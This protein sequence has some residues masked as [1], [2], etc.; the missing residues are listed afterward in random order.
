MRNVCC[1]LD[2]KPED[3]FPENPGKVI[4][5]TDG[6]QA[7]DSL[8]IVLVPSSRLADT[9]PLEPWHVACETLRCP[10]VKLSRSK[11]ESLLEG[12][13]QCKDEGLEDWA[14]TSVL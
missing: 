10:V 2:V 5:E 6:F 4:C 1:F 13:L 11:Y 12:I 7:H 14:H 3:V 9:D 8:K